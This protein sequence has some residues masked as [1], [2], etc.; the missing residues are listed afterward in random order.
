M[1]DSYHLPLNRR[2]IQPSGLSSVSP[3]RP[4]LQN[5]SDVW[6]MVKQMTDVLLRPAKDTLK[7]RTS[8]EM[9]MAFVRQALSFL[10]NRCVCPAP[11]LTHTL[12]HFCHTV[13]QCDASMDT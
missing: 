12:C 3:L 9:H 11:P 4:L 6:L 7:S 10:E 1:E 2:L 8:V 13:G 5:V